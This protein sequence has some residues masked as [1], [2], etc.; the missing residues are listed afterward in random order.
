[1][2]LN[3]ITICFHLFAG[4]IKILHQSSL[5]LLIV[6]A[7]YN[8]R[9]NKSLY[10]KESR[11][12][13]DGLQNHT[14]N[15]FDAKWGRCLPG[16]GSKNRVTVERDDSYLHLKVQQTIIIIISNF[17]QFFRSKHKKKKLKTKSLHSSYQL[18]YSDSFL[19]PEFQFRAKKLLLNF[20]N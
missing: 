4:N 17:G 5:Y 16:T 13:R 20:R 18:E 19:L 7:S 12:P 8:S 14:L 6:E 9:L 15:A 1:M 11:L 10:L 2:H 3:S